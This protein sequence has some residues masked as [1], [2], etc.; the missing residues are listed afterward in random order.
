MGVLK[1]GRHALRPKGVAPVGVRLLPL[2]LPLPLPLLL[3]LL[4][5]P[6]PCDPWVS[7]LLESSHWGMPGANPTL[8]DCLLDAVRWLHTALPGGE[9]HAT[10]TACWPPHLHPDRV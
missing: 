6:Q 9:Q 2:P 3:P 1:P 4:L 7:L 5:P 10:V 8:P